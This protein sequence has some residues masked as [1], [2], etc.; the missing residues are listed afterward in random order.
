MVTFIFYEG[1]ITPPSEIGAIRD[2]M[3]YGEIF[4][5]KE[6]E[7]LLEA[8]PHNKDIYYRWLKTTHLYDYITDIV[9][10]EEQVSGLRISETKTADPYVK[11]ERITFNNLQNILTIFF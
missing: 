7:Y 11:L 2:L 4:C 8:E 1:I 5:N 3:L 10:P 9:T 6:Y